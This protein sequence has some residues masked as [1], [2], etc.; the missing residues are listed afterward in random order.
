M[1]I[2][3]VKVV[4]ACIIISFHISVFDTMSELYF[5]TFGTVLEESQL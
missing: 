2:M 4:H 3:G 5:F 1:E